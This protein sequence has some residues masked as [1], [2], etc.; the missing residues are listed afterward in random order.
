MSFFAELKRR[1]VF[2]VGIAYVLMGWILLQGADFGLDLIDAPNWVIQV[3]AL[4]V[5]IGFPLALFFAWA[6]EMTPE[7][8]KREHE[9]DRTQSIT[10]K[11]GRKLD[12]IIIGVLVLIIV[13]MAIE[14]VFIAGDP[15]TEAPEQVAT[16]SGPA[17]TIAVLPFNDLSQAQD[18]GWFAEGL[19]DEILNALTRTPDLLVSS[20]TSS[21]KY[22]G[23]KLDISQI[24][25]ELGVA[26]VLEGSVRSSA[27][28]IRVTAQLIRAEDGFHVWSENYDRDVA[29]MISIQEDLARNIATA[30]ETTMDP[31]ALAEMSQAGT[32]SV[33]AYQ[34]YLKGIK[35]QTNAINVSD[36]AQTFRR[37]YQHF[38]RAREIDPGFA[39]AHVQAADYWKVQMSPS[40]T[41]TGTSGLEPLEILR[42]YHER[43]GA[44]S[45]NAKTEAARIRSLA[46]R[47]GVDLRLRE[48]I[49]LFRQYLEL[50]PNDHQARFELVGVAGMAS[51]RETLLEELAYYR[52]RGETDEYAAGGYINEAYRV[53]DPSEAADFGLQSVERWPNS[54]GMIYQ[55]HRT[56]V[57][58]GRYQEASQLAARH[59]ALVPGG[60]PLVRARE[61]CAAGDR[62]AAE[63]ILASLDQS[64]NNLLSSVWL[65]HNMLGNK[66]EEVETLRPL[67]STGVPFQ[68]ASLLSYHKFDPRPFPTLMAVLEREGVERPP[69]VIPPFRCPP[70]EQMS[71]AVLPFV[72]MSADAENEYF[73]DG[74]AEE[75]LNVLARIPDLKV[76]ARTSAFAFKGSN[77][78]ISEIAG[79]L[80]VNHVLE[81]SVR[82]AGNQVRV[83]AQLIKADDGFHM[84]SD[85]YDRELTNI[86][87]IQDEIAGHI[88]N[89]LKVHLAPAPE[90]SNLTGT[91][92]PEAYDA[93]L[94]G[95]NQWHLR[96]GESLRA[97]ETLFLQAIELDPG[98]ARAH[99]GL[100]LTY[101][102]IASY[103]NEPRDS[104]MMKT[105]QAAEAALALDENLAE[106]VAALIHSTT[107]VPQRLAFGRRAIALNP[108]FA[109]AHQWH[110]A[111]LMI[112]GDL[113]ASLNSYRQAFELDPRSRIIGQ[114]L[115]D[116][117][118]SQGEIAEAE[119]IIQRVLSFAPNFRFA[120]ESQLLLALQTGDRELAEATASRLASV[121]GFPAESTDVY[122][123]LLGSSGERQA[124]LEWIA[125]RPAEEWTTSDEGN[126]LVSNYTAI[127]VLAYFGAPTDALRTM[128]E[129]TAVRSDFN[130][131]GFIRADRTIPEL[132]CREDAQAFFLSS[133]L[134]PMVDPYPCDELL[135]VTDR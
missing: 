11:T 124:A 36:E 125:Q 96:T 74:V 118:W 2:R 13:F 31:A 16:V 105:R 99:A 75:I 62:D 133:G 22:K 122:I 68:L 73:S 48:A 115:A 59:E 103:I 63:A 7:G 44:A 12:F 30:L 79:E 87:A 37:A 25:A 32:R 1:N 18:Q 126:Q 121:R 23:S 88:A 71:I 64:R 123:D 97:A 3:F 91:T 41:D 5:V 45:E 52:K 24:A 108:S 102:V 39:D 109:S 17:K 120:L 82:K 111:T 110:G 77:S 80:G 106:A 29:D 95:I 85:S 114:N 134:P 54:T 20:R 58:A 107:D 14:R 90:Q 46:D 65:L 19:A 70:P 40:R 93:Y 43:I 56:L 6:F 86:F 127:T 53:V 9:V 35:L 42:E 49:R 116:T 4:A 84:W 21:F 72:N 128:Q 132:N 38:E 57:W 119:R 50:R 33:E 131:L 94:R 8:I 51:D 15:E 47:A 60:N 117:L 89:A 27:D 69:P 66:H 28:R 55:T 113:T 78:S 76:A 129:N 34:E 98:F 83:T 112:A 104:Y 81:G 92:N 100:A 26:H 101:A 10:P 135:G 130:L 67:E 61:A